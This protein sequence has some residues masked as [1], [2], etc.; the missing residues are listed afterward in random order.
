VKGK[1]KF[2]QV[3]PDLHMHSLANTQQHTYNKYIGVKINKQGLERWLS[4]G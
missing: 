3:V 1:N 2:W 4:G